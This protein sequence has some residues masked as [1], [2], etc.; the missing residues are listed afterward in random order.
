MN[1]LIVGAGLHSFVDT[2]KDN[3]KDNRI[4]PRDTITVQASDRAWEL[5]WPSA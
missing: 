4:S 5:T 3:M 2:T 1:K